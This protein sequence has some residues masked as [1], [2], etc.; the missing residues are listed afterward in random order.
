LRI[1]ETRNIQQAVPSKE[2]WGLFFGA[3]MHEGEC[4]ALGFNGAA[5][6]SGKLGD[7]FAAESAAKVPE[8][9]EKNGPLRDQRSQALTA[10]RCIGSEECS[11]DWA[12]PKHALARR[13]WK[14]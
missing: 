4:C 7:S 9:H 10:L 8:K 1:A 13:L 2:P 6:F 14:F 5:L 3:Q 11:V 12:G